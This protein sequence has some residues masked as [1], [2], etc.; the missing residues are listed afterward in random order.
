MDSSCNVTRPTTPLSAW[1]ELFSIEWVVPNVRNTRLLRYSL[2]TLQAISDP[3]CQMPCLW[4]CPSVCL[5][6]GLCCMDNIRATLQSLQRWSHVAYRLA[7]ISNQQIHC[8]HAVCVY[9]V[10]R[11]F[12]WLTEDWQCVKLSSTRLSLYVA[13]YCIPLNSSACHTTTYVYITSCC[14]SLSLSQS[15]SIV[16]KTIS[17]AVTQIRVYFSTQTLQFNAFAALFC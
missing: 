12:L 1:A 17:D 9:L 3:Y 2:A 10:L 7:K 4:L 11:S 6:H 13:E 5:Q 8:C 16:H 15:L 14:P